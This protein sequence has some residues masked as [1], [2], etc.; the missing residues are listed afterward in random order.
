M[1]FKIMKIKEWL[2]YDCYDYEAKLEGYHL[3]VSFCQLEDGTWLAEASVDHYYT[4][5]KKLPART[6][7]AI[8]RA[9]L[10]IWRY[11]FEVNP[12]L[13][14]AQI[15]VELVDPKATA[16]LITKLGFKR[17]NEYIYEL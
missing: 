10:K 1:G 5:R 9:L 3:Q 15:R 16:S 4:R 17:I 12:K 8:L 14:N 6:R 13:K 2:N 7:T 11:A